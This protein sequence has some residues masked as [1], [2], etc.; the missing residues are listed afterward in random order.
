MEVNTIAQKIS[1]IL[2]QNGINMYKSVTKDL[3]PT[4]YNTQQIN[5]IILNILPNITVNQKDYNYYTTTWK[6]WNDL[7]DSTLLNLLQWIS[8]KQ[9]CDNHAILFSSL[10]IILLGMN[11]CGYA[12]GSIY[13]KDTGKF[14]D[15]HYFDIVVTSDKELYCVESQTY[16]W[17]KIEKG[18]DIVIGTWRYTINNVTLF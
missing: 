11:S 8:E 13:N 17:V 15:N 9:D 14:I 12:F 18:K 2:I 6:D 4:V 16:K 7:L 10:S 1:G 3:I 5:T